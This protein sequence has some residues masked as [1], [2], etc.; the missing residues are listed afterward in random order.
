MDYTDEQIEKATRN[1]SREMLEAISSSRISNKA[2]EIGER[3][4]LNENQLNE[5]SD[6]TTDLALGLIPKKEF[7][8]TLMGL[9]AITD[10]VA[11]ALSLDIDREIFQKI[12]SVS[13]KQKQYE[14]LPS[15]VQEAII[16]VGVANKLTALTA[17]YKLHL[18]KAEELSD[19]TSLVMLGIT[20]PSD[21]MKNLQ[22]RLELPEDLARDLVA[23]VNE[24]IF[25]PIR[26]SLKQIHGMTNDPRLT[27]NDLNPK[28]QTLNPAPS[29]REEITNEDLKIM[30]D[31]GVELEQPTTNNQQLTIDNAKE[32]E[33]KR[34]E[35]MEGLENPA[36]IQ[37]DGEGISGGFSMLKNAPIASP[38]EKLTSAIKTPPTEANYVPINNEQSTINNKE[39]KVDPYREAVS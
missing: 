37:Q 10:T 17:K 33:L 4:G 18:D 34:G 22:R 26:E 3:Y 23:D 35:I 14:S 1:L 32:N 24:Q 19:E 27:T 6:T 39:M 7:S 11:T 36:G 13:F 29:Y 31:S 28:P 9:L 8:N 38:S 21:Y 30:A 2:R 20:G 12:N 5:L 16:S 15:D 25:K